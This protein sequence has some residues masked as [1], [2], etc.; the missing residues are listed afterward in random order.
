MK[1]N[2]YILI[3]I[4]IVLIISISKHKKPIDIKNISIDNI[5][6]NYV[7]DLLETNGNCE[8]PCWWGITP[9]VTLWE[10]A[11]SFLNLFNEN[12]YKRDYEGITS[13]IYTFLDPIENREF[14]I[15][16]LVRNGI[17]DEIRIPPL[18]FSRLPFSDNLPEFLNIKNVI[19]KFGKPSLI[20]VENTFLSNEPTYLYF[21]LIYEEKNYSFSFFTK[22]ID[23]NQENKTVC[24]FSNPMIVLSKNDRT[25]NI[26][27][28]YFPS[29]DWHSNLE[30]ISEYSI[31][32]FVQTIKDNHDDMCLIFEDG[33]FGK[34]NM[35]E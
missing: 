15:D 7:S 27:P 35:R 18:Y 1:K 12:L 3:L 17:V 14:N 32:S 30:E 25:E 8:F 16:F 22:E 9:G 31:S 4:F 33:F 19:L 6:D 11:Q 10:D 20:K 34:L 28:F 24:F 23:L 29:Y 5:T 2:V 21:S 26:N 13:Y